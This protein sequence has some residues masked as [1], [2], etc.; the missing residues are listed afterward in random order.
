MTTYPDTL[1][2]GANQYKLIQKTHYKTWPQDGKRKGKLQNHI[3]K[4]SNSECT[5]FYL[6]GRRVKY[7]KV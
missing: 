5:N 1:Q 6:R 7:L 3:E 2:V 4:G